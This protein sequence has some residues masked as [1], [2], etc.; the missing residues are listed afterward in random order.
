MKDIFNDL[1]V[2]AGEI[3]SIVSMNMNDEYIGMQVK[4]KGEDTIYDFYVSKKEEKKDA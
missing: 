4:P 3:G 2:F 1:I